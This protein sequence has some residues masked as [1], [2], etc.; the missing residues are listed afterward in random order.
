LGGQ[1]I[2][3]FRFHEPFFG[4]MVYRYD[5]DK[6]CRQQAEEKTYFCLVCDMVVRGMGFEPMQPYGNRS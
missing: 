4:L 3:A 5:G 6:D 1:K 2:N